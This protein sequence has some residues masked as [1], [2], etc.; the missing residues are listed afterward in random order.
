MV[1]K[2]NNLVAVATTDKNGDASFLVNTEAPGKTY[3]YA[4]GAIV[5]TPDGWNAAAP[6]NLCVADCT[7]DDYT[8]DGQ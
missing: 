5:N 7:Y 1:Y 8:E 4:A 3:D 2:A 6:K